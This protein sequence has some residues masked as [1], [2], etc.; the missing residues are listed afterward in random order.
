KQSTL[1]K[2]KEKEQ[3]NEQLRQRQLW[4]SIAGGLLSLLLLSLILVNQS[5]KRSYKALLLEKEKVEQLLAEKENLLLHLKETQEQ[6]VQSEKMASIGQLTAG[7]AHEINNPINFIASGINALKVNLADIDQVLNQLLTL[8]NFPK[9]A[10]INALI[11][12]T[13]QL[14]I[15]FLNQE[16]K[17]ITKSIIHGVQR[18]E[19]IITG[20]RNFARKGNQQFQ[21]ADVEMGIRSTLILIKHKM[22]KDIQLV[23]SF[24]KIP[25]IFCQIDRLNQVILNL[26][27]NAIDAMPNGGTLTISTKKLV[28]ER[29]QISIADTGI[30]MDA[31]TLN[32]L[33]D[34]FFTTKTIGKGTGLGL[35]ISYGII[36][37]HQGTIEVKSV[38]N[39]GS[40][41]TIILPVENS[42]QRGE[43]RE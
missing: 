7:I 3:E 22:G 19:N 37:D 14:E 2:T 11:A 8:G 12:K 10:D 40:T 36:K 6:L 20:L 28:A 32:H 35:A 1:F 33:F 18:T 13:Q 27:T 16:N 29:V 24:A 23:K 41:F 17:Q 42:A 34:P 25:P 43:S 9:Q 5:R 39:E 30:G 21:L 26:L 15:E 4:M 38:P 31:H